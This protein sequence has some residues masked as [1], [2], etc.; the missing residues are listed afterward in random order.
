MWNKH[1][2]PG[3]RWSSGSSL[4]YPLVR[5]GIM[6]NYSNQSRSFRVQFTPVLPKHRGPRRVLTFL[7]LARRSPRAVGHGKEQGPVFVQRSYRRAGLR[8]MFYWQ[9]LALS[10]GDSSVPG[11]AEGGEGAPSRSCPAAPARKESDTRT[12]RAVCVSGDRSALLER[13][14]NSCLRQSTA[15]PLLSIFHRLTKQH[16]ALGEIQ[17]ECRSSSH[18]ICNLKTHYAFCN[19]FIFFRECD[20]FTNC[21]LKCIHIAECIDNVLFPAAHSYVIF[22]CANMAFRDILLYGTFLLFFSSDQE[23]WHQPVLRQHGPQGKWES[24]HFQLPWHGRQSGKK[25]IKNKC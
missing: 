4:I 15:F 3:Q 20:I 23:C 9:T 13:N 1:F 7:P 21:K 2:F 11:R 24:G 6:S 5:I 18:L 25:E 22:F 14:T 16:R 8:T 17:L 10:V 12:A 19:Y